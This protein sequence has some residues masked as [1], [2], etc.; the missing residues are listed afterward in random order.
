M[1]SPCAG[2]SVWRGTYSS[3]VMAVYSVEGGGLRKVPSTSVAA[4]SLSMLT[5]SS[6]LAFMTDT[7]GIKASDSILQ[8]VLG[9]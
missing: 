9:T 3:P 2:Q 1:C 4:N 7:F 5:G 8:Y 6:V